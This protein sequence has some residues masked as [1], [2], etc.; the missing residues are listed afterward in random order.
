MAYRW[1]AASG[2]YRDLQTGRFIPGAVVREAVD[3]VCDL[4]AERLAGLSQ[5]LLDGSIS[6]ADWQQQAMQLV[7]A[8]HLAAGVAA[9]GGRAQMAPADYGAI[10]RRLR[11]EY[12]YLRGFAQEIADGRQPLD[13]RLVARARLYGQAARSNYE[14][15]R[16]RDDRTRGMAV[17]RNVLGAGEHC[18]VCPA[19]AR[20]G[21]VPIGTLPPVGARPCRSNDRCTIERRRAAP[22]PSPS[23]ES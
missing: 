19:L 12:A 23:D 10:G 3:R 13:G 21:W 14:A 8:T 17:E 9:H 16:L 18:S 7:K 5:R 2:R 22:Q 11:D 1:D 20:R 4:A 6:L 15:V